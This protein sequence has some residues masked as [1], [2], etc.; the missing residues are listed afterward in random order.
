MREAAEFW[1][2]V[3][4][5]PGAAPG[6]LC[7]P[8]TLKEGCDQRCLDFDIATFAALLSNIEI[9]NLHKVQTFILVLGRWYKTP[10]YDTDF[11]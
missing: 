7:A 11:L 2:N 1:L 9:E 8:L 10:D 3:Q 5:P 4:K 6:L